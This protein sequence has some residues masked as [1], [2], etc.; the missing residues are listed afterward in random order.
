MNGLL[1]ET[2]DSIVHASQHEESTATSTEHD[3]HDT[4]ETHVA[5]KKF[6]PCPECG[7]TEFYSARTRGS[8]MFWKHGI[9]GK[10]TSS[11]D[12]K[13]KIIA[14]KTETAKRK[15]HHKKHPAATPSKSEPT[16][17]QSVAAHTLYLV[18]YLTHHI[19]QYCHT[20]HLPE[21]TVTREVGVGLASRLF[22]S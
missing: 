11:K 18:G 10:S 16:M 21:A 2:L 4:T 5:K 19:E 7:Q 12:H 6:D 20:H 1:N 8:H 14:K 15:S 22:H 9:P 17:E 13:K 3:H